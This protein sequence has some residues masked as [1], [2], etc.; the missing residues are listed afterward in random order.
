VPYV[1]VDGLRIA[2]DRQGSGRPMLCVHGASQD[3]TS[4]R[5]NVEYFSQFFDVIAMDNPGHGKSALPAEG[6]LRS[7]PELAKYAWGVIRELGLEKPI[8]MGHSLG[9]A[10]VL[11]LGVEHPD[12]VGAVVDVDGAARTAAG[13][14]NYRPGV[15]DLVQINPTD[16]LETT[17]LSVLGRTTPMDRKREMASDARRVIPEVALAD[18]YAYTSCNF[19]DELHRITAPVI[20]VVGEDDWSCSPELTHETYDAVTAP[21]SYHMFEGI[22]HIPHTEQPDE[23]NAVVHRLLDEHGLLTPA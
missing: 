13:V 22:G 1:N 14:T 6:P 17:F 3:S 18:L 9:G 8:V 2:Y 11:R 7:I 15:L 16:W 23:F 12:D 4:W 5:F 19:V 21:K 10:I 20:A